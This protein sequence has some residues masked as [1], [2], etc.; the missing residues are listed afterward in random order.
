MTL[1]KYVYGNDSLYTLTFEDGKKIKLTEKELQELYIQ[2]MQNT[3]KG[4]VPAS[5]ERV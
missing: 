1:E 3:F 5:N 4:L 2:L